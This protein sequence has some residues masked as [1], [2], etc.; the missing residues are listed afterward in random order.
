MRARRQVHGT[1]CLTTAAAAAWWAAATARATG[2]AAA[3]ASWRASAAAVP[4]A[5]RRAAAPAVTATAS[6]PVVAATASTPE[7]G[8]FPKLLLHAV[9]KDA[10][11]ATTDLFQRTKHQD[12]L[13]AVRVA[14][15]TLVM[16][17]LAIREDKCSGLCLDLTKGNTPVPHQ[18][19]NDAAGDID[20]R[21][22]IASLRV[23]MDWALALLN[24]PL[25][26]VTA[27]SPL[28]SGTRDEGSVTN[29]LE[30][31]IRS[32]CKLLAG[33]T[34]LSKGIREFII[35]DRV[36]RDSEI[37]IVEALKDI[38]TGLALPVQKESRGLV[39]NRG[40]DLELC[41]TAST[42]RA[43]DGEALR[44]PVTLSPTLA[45]ILCKEHKSAPFFLQRTKDNTIFAGH[46]PNAVGRDIH[47]SKIIT[48]CIEI[49]VYWSNA[50]RKHELHILFGPGLCLRAT[51]DLKAS[52]VVELKS[53]S[54]NTG[55]LLLRRA[56]STKDKGN[57][58]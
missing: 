18:V 52:V 11:G 32:A 20:G 44:L 58:I 31:T 17:S 39:F 27:A 46:I 24:E 50:L 19:P 49:D 36:G 28:R 51:I 6:T 38:T 43:K 3:A 25:E 21:Y 29:V 47:S 5:T 56:A 34:L 57:I 40:H 35:S 30:D 54:S 8:V 22:V 55:N 41:A 33:G 1:G 9:L 2:A 7:T 48:T 13:S 4:T 37:A 16:W 10:L 15:G 12:T 14:I 45:L 42:R 26:V 53:S 23:N